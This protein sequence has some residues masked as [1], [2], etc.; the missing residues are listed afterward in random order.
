MNAC[1]WRIKDDGII[2]EV[3]VEIA[4]AGTRLVRL[5][6]P[7]QRLAAAQILSR[8]GS[9]DDIERNLGIGMNTA[10]RI[11]REARKAGLVTP[12]PEEPENAY[13]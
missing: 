7:E 12:C 5:T 1:P 4:A 9:N 13:A 3:A 6:R 2:D 10:L 8:G 11:E